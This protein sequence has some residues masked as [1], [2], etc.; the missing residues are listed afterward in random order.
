MEEDTKLEEQF[1]YKVEK[2]TGA[3]GLDRAPEVFRRRLTFADGAGGE[4]VSCILLS[5]AETEDIGVYLG[6][7]FELAVKRLE[8]S[9]ENILEA[10]RAALE[11]GQEYGEGKGLELNFIHCFFYKDACYVCRLGDKISLL[12]FRGADAGHVDIKIGSGPISDGQIYL[13]A[14]NK[15]LDIFDTKILTENNNPDLGEVIDGLATAISDYEDQSEIGAVFI[16]AKEQAEKAKEVQEFA[17]DEPVVEEGRLES[18]EAVG[19]G[20]SDDLN[21]VEVPNIAHNRSLKIKNP[22][23]NIVGNLLRELRGLRRGDLRAIFRLRRN[24]VALCIIIILILAGSVSYNLYG[25]NKKNK[26][27]QV[28]DHLSLASSKYSEAQALS[29]INKSRARTLLVDADKEVKAALAVD[30]KNVDANKLNDEISAKLKD[31][32][33]A[34]SVNFETL[35]EFSDSVGGMAFSG[36]NL[37][38]VHSNKLSIINPGTKKTDDIDVATGAKAVAVY[39]GNAFVLSGGKTEKIDLASKK[40]K[41]VASE[42]GLDMDVFFGNVYILGKAQIRKFVPIENG[43]LG[44]D[45]LAN[46]VDFGDFSR[47]TIDAS[48]W[49]TK[50]DKILKFTRGSSENFEI[51]G[52]VNANFTLGAIYT[53]ADIDNLY[54]VDRANSVLLVI[55]KKGVYKKVYQGAEFA[56]VSDL[57]VDE[58]VGKMYLAVGSKVLAA[59]L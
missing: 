45:Y 41:D 39:S 2:I 49:V 21:L 28:A 43:Y 44:S 38:V 18:L 53:N 8:D 13:I 58:T 35:S 9:S 7:I 57:V 40:A 51:S 50:G 22:L 47:M 1:T 56:K 6:D 34:T 20:K 29:E 27:Q 36:K 11:S 48:V 54:V 24:I 37:A 30:S 59:T 55:D 33:S 42:S 26:L 46:K 3:R 25:Q 31:T 32:E 5:G 14:T 52:L 12:T 4:L 15:F 16:G 10:L 19:I 23:P 17:V